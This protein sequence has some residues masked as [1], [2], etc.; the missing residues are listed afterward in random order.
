MKKTI[1]LAAL[2]LSVCLII[3]VLAACGNLSA[4]ADGVTYVSLRINPEIEL[5]ADENG[6]VLA[7][8]AVNTDGETVLLETE[9]VG[10]TVEEAGGHSIGVP[11]AVSAKRSFIVPS[12]TLT[13]HPVRVN[14]TVIGAEQTYAYLEGVQSRIN[15]FIL[16][17]SQITE[18]R[19]RELMS[20]PDKLASDIGTVLDGYEAVKE[21]L[22]GSIG[23]L[24][25]AMDALRAMIDG[26][27]IR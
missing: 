23:G 19:L 9:L 11:L 4:D 25:D 22:I 20:A 1:Q 14:G 16:S 3:P 12:A 13:L 17:H 7:A 6:E 27:A 10:M 26:D 18:A 21:G 24:S 2:L 15:R 5:I 8:N